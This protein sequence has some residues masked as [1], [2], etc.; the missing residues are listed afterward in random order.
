MKQ[1]AT[2]SGKKALADQKYEIILAHILHPDQSPLPVDQQEQYNRVIQAAKLLDSLAPQNVIPRLLAKYN[3]SR[4]QARQDVKLAQ[5]LFKTEFTFDWDYWRSWQIKDLID[6]IAWCKLHNNQRDRVAA[7][8]VLQKVIGE[9]PEGLEDPHR[10]EKNV[11]NIQLNN[12]GT[13]ITLPLD[14]IR[15]LSPDQ[16]RTLTEE[17]TSPEQKTDDEVA[18]ILET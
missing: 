7:N 15:S 16:L 9:K 8:K 10:V 13:I 5:E 18:E 14:L 4:T 1:L 12:S 6:T 17:I 2:A 3:I 11:F